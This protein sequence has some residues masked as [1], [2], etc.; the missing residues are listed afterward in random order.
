MSALYSELVKGLPL[1]DS[2]FEVLQPPLQELGF[3]VEL[4]QVDDDV[5]GIKLKHHRVRANGRS[6]ALLHVLKDVIQDSSGRFLINSLVEYFI[7]DVIGLFCFSETNEISEVYEGQANRWLNKY[8]KIQAAKFIKFEVIDKLM[9]MD[10]D[11]RAAFLNNRL[12]LSRLFP[13]VLAPRAS[14]DN[15]HGPTFE[16]HLDGVDDVELQGLFSNN[17]PLL[18]VGELE[19]A[20]PNVN[21]VCLIKINGKSEGTGFLVADDLVLTNHHVMSSGF[22]NTEEQMLANARY[23]TLHFGYVSPVKG[24]PKREQVFK[25]DPKELIVAKNA[26]LDF[27]LL[28]VEPA[29]KQAENLKVVEFAQEPATLRDTIHML[30]HPG[31]QTMQLALSGNAITYVSDDATRLEYVT[32][33]AKGS[34][35]SPCFNE[36][37]KVVALHRAEE[38][39]RFARVIG[40]GTIR[41][42]VPFSTIHEKIANH[43][44][45]NN[46]PT[47]ST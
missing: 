15:R 6:I 42:G 11:S 26:E 17:S 45:T 2:L 27:A 4:S 47:K 7:E 18:D 33:A 9:K 3:T 5:E 43:L 38:T 14:S 39:K 32:P 28:R 34:S 22:L 44:K 36:D 25:L 35:G 13:V 37:W 8:S 12:I 21:S 29:I 19:R 20:M 1:P 10:V 40:V 41:Q 46:D 24:E 31:G 16:S 23:T 30:Q